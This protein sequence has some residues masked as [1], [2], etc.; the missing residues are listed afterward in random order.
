MN[1][2]LAMILLVFDTERH[3][4]VIGCEPEYLQ[5]DVYAVFETMLGKLGIAKIYEESEQE[6]PNLDLKPSDTITRCT[7]ISDE[8]LIQLD[9]ELYRH[10]AKNEVAPELH[11]TRWLRCVL[12]REFS[13]ENCVLLWDFIFAGAY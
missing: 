11:L 1:E 3:K 8:Y 5:H 10:L 2:L 6:G 4:G 13:V 9:N 12:S 7:R